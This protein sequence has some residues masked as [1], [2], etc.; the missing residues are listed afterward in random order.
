[1]LA[2]LRDRPDAREEQAACFKQ[3]FAGLEGRGIDFRADETSL[4][5]YGQAVADAVPLAAAL[6]THLL[7]RG[8]GE[9]SLAPGVSPTSL[10]SVMRALAAPAGL[11]RSLH[12]LLGS[13][14]E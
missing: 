14:D 1:M 10:L 7:D 9:L 2:L 3:L 8:I 13:L 11:H 6:R 5:A 4:R 12:E